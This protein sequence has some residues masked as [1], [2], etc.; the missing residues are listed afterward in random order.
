MAIYQELH[1]MRDKD[2]V[3][4][5]PPECTRDAWNFARFKEFPD[6]DMTWAPGA[7]S[8]DSPTP[9]AFLHPSIYRS[10]TARLTQVGR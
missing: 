5:F 9:T 4:G 7:T 8:G 2:I 6:A 1:F 10:P 3:T